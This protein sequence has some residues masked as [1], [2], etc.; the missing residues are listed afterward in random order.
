MQLLTSRRTNSVC[1][2]FSLSVEVDWRRQVRTFLIGGRRH[3]K[4][5]QTHQKS[6]ASLSTYLFSKKEFSFK[7]TFIDSFISSTLYILRSINS[8]C[9]YQHHLFVLWYLALRSSEPFRHVNLPRGS[10]AF[11][12]TIVK[13][14]KFEEQLS[15]L[16]AQGMANGALKSLITCI[17]TQCNSYAQTTP[18]RFKKEL[19]KACTQANPSATS[20][21][22]DSL[23]QLLVNI[24]HPDEKLSEA[25]L[26]LLLAEAGVAESKRSIP[27]DK[28]IQLM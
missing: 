2:F 6:K 16:S 10:R 27:V 4:K 19:I 25:D 18:C 7:T 23:N 8:S 28:I 26:K 17:L 14:S 22:I 21:E 20:I 24:G 5:F 9:W 11:S 12:K 15:Q 1:P 13:R 3:I